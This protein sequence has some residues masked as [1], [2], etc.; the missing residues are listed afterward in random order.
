MEKTL[1]NLLYAGIGL[2]TEA[3]EKVQSEVDKLVEKG[4][5]ADS[6]IKTTVENFISKTETK[7][8][9][10]ETKFNELISKFGYA[11]TSEV[12]ALRQKL[13]KLEAEA[14]AKTTKT[15]KAAA[16]TAKA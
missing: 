9:E 15:V 2:A 11:K 5:S 14:A 6:E 12:E 4:K 13:E 8:G 3:T 1:K 16:T 7:A 10:F